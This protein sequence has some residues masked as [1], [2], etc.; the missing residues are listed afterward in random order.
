MFLSSFP[1]SEHSRF[2]SFFFSFPHFQPCVVN[3]KRICFFFFSFCYSDLPL[4][5]LPFFFFP[6]V[7]NPFRNFFFLLTF[8]KNVCCQVTY[9]FSPLLS[10]SSH[11]HASTLLRFRFSPSS[12]FLNHPFP[13]TD[14]LFPLPRFPPPP[15]SRPFFSPSFHITHTPAPIIAPS[16]L[17]FTHSPTHASSSTFLASLAS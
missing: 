16:S 10:W 2:S 15:L 6:Y 17:P 7:F 14:H 13:F 3:E 8:R 12:T 11:L 5:T 9:F 4:S 1:Q